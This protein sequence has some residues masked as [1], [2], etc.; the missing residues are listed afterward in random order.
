MT[1]PEND[2]QITIRMPSKLKT[3]VDT[4]TEGIGIT[5][6]EFIRRAIIEKLERDAQSG[7]ETEPVYM[8][9]DVFRTY[10]L[11]TI[12]NDTELQKELRLIIL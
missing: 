9:K 1:R 6:M 8:T 12:K 2:L 4:Y 5:S 11:E 10:L 7:Y 3:R